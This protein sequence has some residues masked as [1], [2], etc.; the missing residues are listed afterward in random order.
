MNEDDTRF[1]LLDPAL[2]EKGY[3]SRDQITLE[4]ILT[5]APVEPT[6]HKGRR[7][8]G[9]GRTGGAK[10]DKARQAADAQ[11]V[12]INGL[13]SQLLAQTFSMPSGGG[14]S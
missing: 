13:S 1:H 3:L 2:R 4:T 10:V 12:E 5:P 14:L 11:L 8:K 9:P 7:R 6:G